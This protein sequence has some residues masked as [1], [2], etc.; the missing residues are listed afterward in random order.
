VTEEESGTE[1]LMNALINKMESMDRSLDS[2]KQENLELKKMIQ[3]PRNLLKRAGFVS[4]QTPLS[5]GVEPDNFRAD[6]DMGEA[7]LLKGGNKVDMGEMSN[8][9]VHQMSWDDIHE[10]ADNTKKVEVL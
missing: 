9:D 6:L 10:L 2:L 4:V 8:E 7:T 1:R 3:Q 5:E